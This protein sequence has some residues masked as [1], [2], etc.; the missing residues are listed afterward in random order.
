[1]DAEPTHKHY[2]QNDEGFGKN[3]FAKESEEGEGKAEG[4]EYVQIGM[5][6]FSVLGVKLESFYVGF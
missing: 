4:Y 5:E 1:M 2:S 3:V 6:E